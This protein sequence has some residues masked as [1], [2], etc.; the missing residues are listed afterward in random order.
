MSRQWS[1][2]AWPDSGSAGLE[3][4]NPLQ[5]HWYNF[6]NRLYSA[7]RRCTARPNKSV[8]TEMGRIEADRNCF[9]TR[10]CFWDLPMTSMGL[11]CISE[12]FGV[13]SVK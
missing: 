6:L 1:S 3:T 4:E 12:Q 13:G 5:N 9:T 11:E 10:G 7:G 8:G 2:C